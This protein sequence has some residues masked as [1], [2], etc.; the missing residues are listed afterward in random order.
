MKNYLTS[1]KWGFALAA[2]LLTSPAVPAQTAPCPA[3][4]SGG[5]GVAQSTEAASQKVK[6]A[7]AEKTSLQTQAQNIDKGD[8]V[9]NAATMLSNIGSFHFGHSKPKPKT[10]TAGAAPC[11]PAPSNPAAAPSQA[12]AALHTPVASGPPQE[13]TSIAGS[14]LIYSDTRSTQVN[15]AYKRGAAFWWYGNS[16]PLHGKPLAAA[17]LI[18]DSSHVTHMDAGLLLGYDGANNAYLKMVN[19]KDPYAQGKTF[20]VDSSGNYSEANPVPAGLTMPTVPQSTSS[21][22]TTLT[23]PATVTALDG[24]KYLVAFTRPG[25]PRSR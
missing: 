3:T 6:Q 21:N 20:R 10:N 15:Q 18:T 9:S 14:R 8:P 4:N 17:L 13:M 24:G 7:E 16:T 25:S 2:S 23:F 1:V 19:V 12:P 5:S 22:S 11:P